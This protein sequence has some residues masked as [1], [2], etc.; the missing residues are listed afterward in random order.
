MWNRGLPGLDSPTHACHFVGMKNSSVFFT[1]I[2]GLAALVLSC[3]AQNGDSGLVSIFDGS[4]LKGWHVS[5]KTGHSNVSNNTSGGRWV[6]E[7]GAIVG[8]QSVLEYDQLE[9]TEAGHI[10]MQAHQPGSWLEFKRIRVK[11]L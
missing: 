1:A 4:T 5:A 10:E 3:A 7:K 2:T 6:V 9:N 11:E 8:T